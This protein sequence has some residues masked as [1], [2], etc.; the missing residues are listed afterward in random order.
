[1][2]RAKRIG[3]TQKAY[4]W[5]KITVFIFQFFFKKDK[6][7]KINGSLSLMVDYSVLHGVMMVTGQQAKK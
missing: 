6:I 2:S 7:G 5:G 3:V 1:M 4:I